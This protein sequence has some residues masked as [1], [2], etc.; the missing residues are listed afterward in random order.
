MPA[1]VYVLTA[2]PQIIHRLFPPSSAA[3]SKRQL[4]LPENARGHWIIPE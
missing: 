4:V 3:D 2:E 1:Q